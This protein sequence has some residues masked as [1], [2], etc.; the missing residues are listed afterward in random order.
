MRAYRGHTDWKNFVSNIYCY[1]SWFLKQWILFSLS[2]LRAE[3]NWR[4]I[5]RTLPSNL[6]LPL[7][8]EEI[9]NLSNLRVLPAKSKCKMPSDFWWKRQVF[10]SIDKYFFF[11]F[12]KG[13]KVIYQRDKILFFHQKSEG[14]LHLLFAGIACKIYFLMPSNFDE[15]M[16]LDYD[17]FCPLKMM[18][19]MIIKGNIICWHFLKAL[20]S[21][22]TTPLYFEGNNSIFLRRSFFPSNLRA[23]HTTV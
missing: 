11:S 15:K 12:F 10:F 8:S 16:P 6:K 18:A 21:A 20:P 17:K 5:S 9:F 22:D 3:Y 4:A 7:I 23:F 2:N 14:I 19:F 1:C 13:S